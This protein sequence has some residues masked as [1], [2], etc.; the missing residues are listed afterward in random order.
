MPVNFHELQA[1]NRRRTVGL[2]AFMVCLLVLAAMALEARLTGQLPVWDSFDAFL[3]APPVFGLAALGLSLGYAG[4]SY[5]AGA[6]TVLFLSRARRLDPTKLKE[7]QFKN[8]AEEMALAAGLPCP[9]LWI[10]AD[11]DLNAFATGRDPAHAS[12]AVTQ[13]LLEN[14]NRD[15]LQ[16]VVAHEMGHIRNRDILL[17]LYVTCMLGAILLITEIILRSF[18]F[19]GVRRRSSNRDNGGGAA[20]VLV[21][22]IVAAIVSWIVSRMVAMAISREREYLADATSAELTRN[23]QSL[24]DALQKIHAAVQP[25][26]VAYPATAPLFIDD[27]KGSKLNSKESRLAGLFSTHPPIDQRIRRLEAMAFADAKRERAAQGLNPLTGR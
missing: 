26:A 9:E 20:I 23:P 19:G 21:F 14:M 8:V 1:K 2:V 24:A 22:V 18:R 7:Q 5:F 3:A 12:I 15:E 17:M 16:A 13:G 10:M 11:D 27:P 6:R 25:T 4:V